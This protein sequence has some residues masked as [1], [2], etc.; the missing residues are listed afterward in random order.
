MQSPGVEMYEVAP[1]QTN[2]RENTWSKVISARLPNFFHVHCSV[3][4]H[5]IVRR[6]GVAGFKAAAVAGG[7][8]SL[9]GQT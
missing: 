5:V 7:N 8:I 4:I 2:T 1:K 3:Q 6:G 9:P